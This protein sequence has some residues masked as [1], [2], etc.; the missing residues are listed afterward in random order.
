MKKQL[1]SLFSI[2]FSLFTIFSFSQ[3]FQWQWAHRGGG[4]QI[5]GLAGT[6]SVS[7]EQIFDVKID[8]YNNYYFA[9]TVTNFN[10]EF[11]GESIT[12]YGTNN[13]QTDIYIV[14]TDCEGNFR[15]HTTLGGEASVSYVSIVYL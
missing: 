13:I 10:P 2:F 4:N 5:A 12:K 1:P 7:L 15:W 6:F 11:M 9:G 8:Q 14:S 3:D